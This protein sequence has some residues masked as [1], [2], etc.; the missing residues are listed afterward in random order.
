MDPIREQTRVAPVPPEAAPAE[1]AGS[2]PV[3]AGSG[4]SFQ[5]LLAEELDLRAAAEARRH[6]AAPASSG[7][8]IKLSAHAEQRL[9][10][11]RVP[12]GPQQVARVASAVDKVAGKGGKQALVLLDDLALIVSVPNRTVIT[13]V[14]G[15]RRQE[16]VFTQIDSAVIAS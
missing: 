15:E 8:G 12:W 2:S 1:G 5:E 13:A 3:R 4:A 11:A 7:A 10:S 16:N 9:R 14:P 6:A